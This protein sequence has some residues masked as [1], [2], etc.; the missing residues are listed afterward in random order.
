MKAGKLIVL[1]MLCTSHLFAQSP[2]GRWSATVNVEGV[3]IP[4]R[5]D[6]TENGSQVTG[7][8]FDGKE[9]GHVDYRTISEWLIGPSL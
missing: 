1:A 6:L 2:E 8:F 3:E 4:F 7:S 9:K 5:F